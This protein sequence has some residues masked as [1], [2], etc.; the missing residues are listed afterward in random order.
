MA[1]QKLSW[2]LG[3]HVRFGDLDF[4]I[5]TEGELARAPVIIQ[6]LHSTSPDA[7][8]NMLEELRVFGRE[9]FSPEYLIRSA[10]MVLPF[11]LCNAVETVGHLMVQRMI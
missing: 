7:I 9:L 4:I 1:S 6:T 3:T 2:V 11:G 8:T 5:T 10:P